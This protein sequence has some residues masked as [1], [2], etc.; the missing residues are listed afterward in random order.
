MAIYVETCQKLMV[1]HIV[2]ANALTEYFLK[3]MQIDN[4]I[5]KFR[6]SIYNINNIYIMYIVYIRYAYEYI[7]AEEI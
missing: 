7:F 2:H 4:V 1:M 6:K 5:S 3:Q